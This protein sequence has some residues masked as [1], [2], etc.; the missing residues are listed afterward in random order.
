MPLPANFEHNLAAIGHMAE[1]IQAAYQDICVA[2]GNSWTPYDDLLA[3][4]ADRA[5][6]LC[7]DYPVLARRQRYATT[8]CLTRLAAWRPGTTRLLS[9]LAS[10]GMFVGRC[11]RPP[12]G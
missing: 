10:L 6:A 8:M 5:L 4:A 12:L 1:P 9:D 2:R 7:E 11:A 3:A